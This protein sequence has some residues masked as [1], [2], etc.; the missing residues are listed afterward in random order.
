MILLKPVFIIVIAIIFV[1]G[2]GLSINV[3]AEENLVPSWIKNTV[4]FWADGQVSD[5]EFLNAMGYLVSENIIQTSMPTVSA[6]SQIYIVSETYKIWGIE[7]SANG[8]THLVKCND[9]NDIA[10][11]GGFDVPYHGIFPS[12][13]KPYG[14][15]G[16]DFSLINIASNE[17]GGNATLYVTCMKVN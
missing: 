12:M 17:S 8:R 4:V 14:T 10:I 13:V 7:S 15:N 11:S 9:N 1:T 6:E 5:T 3:S 2:I 16:Y